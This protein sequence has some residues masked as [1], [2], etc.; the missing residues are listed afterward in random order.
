MFVEVC[1]LKPRD[2]LSLGLETSREEDC[3][4]RGWFG[5]KCQYKCHCERQR[6]CDAT[7]GACPNKC[8]TGWFG[9]ACQ[10]VSVTFRTAGSKNLRSWWDRD[11][12]TCQQVFAEDKVLIKLREVLP[13]TWLRIVGENA[14]HISKIQISINAQSV[15]CRKAKVNFKTVDFVCSDSGRTSEMILSNFG[16]TKVCEIYIS[17]G[18]NVALK[19]VTTQSSTYR[20]WGSE[21]AVNGIF[22]TVDGSD[23]VQSSECSRTN[24]GRWSNG[25]WRVSFPE[26]MNII[27]TDIYNRRNPSRRNCCGQSLIGFTLIVYDGSF[28][29]LYSYADRRRHPL[30]IYHVPFDQSHSSSIIKQAMNVK[31]NKAMYSSSL[32]LCEVVIYGGSL[33]QYTRTNRVCTV[34]VLKLECSLAA[35]ILRPAAHPACVATGTELQ[36]T[37]HTHTT[38]STPAQLT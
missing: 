10:Y 27:A 13:V 33:L 5:N 3:R 2:Q 7:T 22:G 29:S 12:K 14:E 31:I 15:F 23:E 9:F 18:R 6:Y 35:K 28:K 24:D 26:P 1:W 11:Y 20:N 37:S 32:N 34:R 30:D 8:E 4:K 25:F 36:I 17:K 38:H 16:F 21:N 19:Q